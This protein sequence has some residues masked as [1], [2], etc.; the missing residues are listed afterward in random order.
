MKTPEHDFTTTLR[1][2]AHAPTRAFVVLPGPA[3][4]FGNG[5]AAD[6]TGT[7]D[8][9]FFHSSYATSDG[10][11]KLTIDSRVL[12]SIGKAPGDVVRVRIEAGHVDHAGG[13]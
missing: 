3:E 5:E 9:H 2:A 6:V 7:I 4:Y 1:T 12:T 10:A 11:P 8:G 13:W